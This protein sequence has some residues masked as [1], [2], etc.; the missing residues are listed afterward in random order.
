MRFCSLIVQTSPLHSM[1]TAPEL[2]SYLHKEVKIQLSGNRQVR[3]TLQ[4]YDM[5]LNLNLTN[6][7]ELKSKDET[8]NIGQCIIRGNS[9]IDIQ[10]Q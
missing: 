6:T 1:I 4:G 7:L 5:F 8:V 10:I 3:G 9:I 2:K